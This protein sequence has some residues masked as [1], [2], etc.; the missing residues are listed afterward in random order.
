[1]QM[2]RDLVD[3]RITPADVEGPAVAQCEQLFGTVSAPG[4]PLWELQCRVARGVLAAGGIPANEL[5]E[6]LAV[7][8]LAEGEPEAGPSWIERALAEGI[9]DQDGDD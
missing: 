1:M 6:W 9:D 2:A 7:T 5:A 8:R 4:D 3:G